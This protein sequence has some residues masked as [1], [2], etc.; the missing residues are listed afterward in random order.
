MLM[1]F[2]K[3]KPIHLKN[4][5]FTS[6]FSLTLLSSL[7]A[8]SSI[9][10]LPCLS[11]ANTTQR[12]KT[13]VEK[14]NNTNGKVMKRIKTTKKTLRKGA[15]RNTST[16]HRI[17]I[18]PV[19]GLNSFTIES[20]KTKTK[21]NEGLMAGFLVEVGTIRTTLETGLIFNQIGAKTDFQPTDGNNNKLET[22]ERFH[23]LEY[24]SFPLIGKFYVSGHRVNGFY[25]KGGV[26]P[27]FITS[28]KEII[29]EKD[30]EQN[31]DVRK[32]FNAV[33][34]LGQI[35]L[36]GKIRLSKRISLAL[37]ASFNRSLAAI[38]KTN[39]KEDNG[40]MFNQGLSLSSGLHIQF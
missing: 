34:Y 40:E 3:F 28:A 5:K 13:V 20:S 17:S 16:R 9:A 24:V 12:I 14:S 32:D 36:G 19:L 29:T 30:K 11:I 35:G 25:L 22:I 18:L 37:D 1:N 7:F 33:D 39:T 23:D 21:A 8:F 6:P 31:K 38:N 15:R 27:S 10:M 4:T 26:I 2:L